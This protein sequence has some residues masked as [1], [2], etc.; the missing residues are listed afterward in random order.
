MSL[1]RSKQLLAEAQATH[2]GNRHA[3]LAAIDQA[4]QKLNKGTSVVS[5]ADRQSNAMMSESKVNANVARDLVS[6]ASTQIADMT[7]FLDLNYFKAKK[8]AAK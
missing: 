3:L 1:G 7:D 6:T 8:R 4:A 2:E 5:Q